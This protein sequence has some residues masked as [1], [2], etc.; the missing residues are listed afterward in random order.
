M[1][2]VNTRVSSRSFTSA[3]HDESGGDDDNASLLVERLRNGS[4]VVDSKNRRWES[5][6]NRGAEPGHLGQA[7]PLAPES[8]VRDVR[9]DVPAPEGA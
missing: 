7:G 8:F 4:C 1:Y 6:A 2:S 5:S 3:D 9:T